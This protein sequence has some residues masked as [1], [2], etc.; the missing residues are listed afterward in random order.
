MKQRIYLDADGVLVDFNGSCE[1]KFGAHPHHLKFDCPER[2]LLKGDR[3]LWAHVETDPN[4]WMD[5]IPFDHAQELVDMARDHDVHI[6]TGCPKSGYDRASEHKKEKLG[7][8]FG[9]PVIT[10]LSKDKPLHMNA[11]GDVL[12]DDFVRNIKRWRE[13]GGVAVYF[14]NWEQARDELAAVI[15]EF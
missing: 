12:V 9:V 8:L 10:C 7:K 13:A 5:M 2:G 3:A 11:P 15:R 6:L 1:R 4:F 14:Q